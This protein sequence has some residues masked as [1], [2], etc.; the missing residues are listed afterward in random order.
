MNPTKTNTEVL[1]ELAVEA[2]KAII[3]SVYLSPQ[4]MAAMADVARD[5]KNS[6][7]LEIAERSYLMAGAMLEKKNKMNAEPKS[8]DKR[9]N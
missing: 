8:N 1:D 2:M 9:K 4:M 6:L 5:N 3:G 7:A